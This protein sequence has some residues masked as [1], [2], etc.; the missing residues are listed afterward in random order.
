MI[1]I[2]LACSTGMST[3]ILMQ[4]MQEYA[5]NN[6]LETKIDAISTIAAKNLLEQYDIVL[7]GP[8]VRYELPSFKN[9]CAPLK[10][11]VDTIDMRDYGMADGEAV[12]NKV[13]YL[14]GKA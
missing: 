12:I 9:L 1:K 4:K 8:Q 7:L 13:L 5:D 6:G 3:S 10:M 11:P 14:L 2:L